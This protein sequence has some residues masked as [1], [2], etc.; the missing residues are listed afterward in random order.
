MMWLNKK[1]MEKRTSEKWSPPLGPTL[2]ANQLSHV[3]LRTSGSYC[4]YC[5]YLFFFFFFFLVNNLYVIFR[6]KVCVFFL[7][8]TSTCFYILLNKIIKIYEYWIGRSKLH[9]WYLMF[10]YMCIIFL[11][12]KK[13][14]LYKIVQ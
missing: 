7:H 3:A 6:R 2:I 13:C 11:A 1:P 4:T 10:V 14:L 5:F 9:D 8:G 12:K